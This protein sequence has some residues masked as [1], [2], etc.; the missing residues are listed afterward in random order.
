M[1]FRRLAVSATGIPNRSSGSHR[2]A[3][4]GAAAVEFAAVA[5]LFVLLILGLIEFG[6][7]VVVQQVITNAS[8]E[9]ARQAAMENTTTSGIVSGIGDFLTSSSVN[10]ATVTVS[11]GSLGDAEYG[12]PVS[13]TVDVGFDQVSW[14]PDPIFLSGVNL[15]ATTVMRREAVD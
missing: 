1:I 12:D 15:S 13:V 2:R 3:R 5:P 6:R 7:M 11:P 14:I 4:T 10:G 9:G 8:R